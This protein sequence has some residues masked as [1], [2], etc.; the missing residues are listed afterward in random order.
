MISGKSLIEP[1][2][3]WLIDESTIADHFHLVPGDQCYYLLEYTSGKDYSFS[4]NNNLIS[5]LK[6]DPSKRTSS[7]SEYRYKTIAV[8]SCSSWI[9]QALNHDWLKKATLIP[10]PPSKVK[11]DPEYDD[12]M[13][14]I[15]RGIPVPFPVDVRELVL[16]R[17]SIRKAHE[18][19]GNRP[20]IAE[21]VANYM[22]DE[23]KATPA[24]TSIAIVDDVLTAGVHFKA[25]QQVLHGRFPGVPLIGI[26]IARRV[27]PND[28]LAGF[29]V[30]DI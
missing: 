2:R 28:Q 10:V 11:T 9:G 29:E 4:F 26:F 3:F 17:D 12:R 24:P 6:K 15:C 25:M 23:R 8:S 30:I 16:Q 22:I 7:P 18:S 20:N 14:Q 1:A 5:N 19:Q 13:L 21:L 27:F